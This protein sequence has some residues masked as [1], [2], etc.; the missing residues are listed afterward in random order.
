MLHLGAVRIG[1]ITVFNAFM[2]GRQSSQKLVFVYENP[3]ADNLFPKLNF[4]QF[5][6]Q[7]IKVLPRRLY[8]PSLKD[9]AWL[10]DAQLIFLIFHTFVCI[11][12]CEPCLDVRLTSQIN[13]CMTS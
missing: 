9:V 10:K 8:S 13:K 3:M 4:S 2:T 12:S 6:N 11:I 1:L 5:V 7:N